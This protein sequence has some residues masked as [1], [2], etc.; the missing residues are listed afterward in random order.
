[1]GAASTRESESKGV[2]RECVEQRPLWVR[3][4]MAYECSDCL[5]KFNF[6]KR[7]HHCRGCGGVFC[8]N[9]MRKEGNL[10]KMGY[11]RPVKQCFTCIY[12][13]DQ[14]KRHLMS[15]L[16]LPSGST[17]Q[18]SVKIVMDEKRFEYPIVPSPLTPVLPGRKKELSGVVSEGKTQPDP[19]GPVL[20]LARTMSDRTDTP[21]DIV[22]QLFKPTTC[23]VTSD[24]YS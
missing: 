21:P 13:V 22:K 3:D 7:R 16:I 9:C 8:A 4:D 2:P 19:F 17:P 5:K 23:L 18:G 14:Q 6:V 11:L 15:S 12:K 24:L 1:M 10:I 20:G